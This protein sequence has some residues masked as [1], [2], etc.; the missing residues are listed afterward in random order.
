MKAVRFHSY[1][2]VDVL[3]YEDVPDPAAGAGEAVVR[4]RA[5]GVGRVDVALRSGQVRNRLPVELPHIPGLEFAGDVVELSEGVDGLSVGDRV[6]AVYQL[7]CWACEQCRAGRQEVCERA[8]IFGID[9][10]G[11]YAEYVV[12][13]T[14]ALVPLP[15]SLSY[16]E[17]AACQTTVGTAWHALLS[18]AR[19][20][21]G[22]TV[23]VSA[24]GSGVGSGG[25]VVGR[26]VGARVLASV[27]SEWKVE[28]ARAAG[29]DVVVDYSRED[30]TQRVLDETAG[31][32]VDVVLECVGGDV[33]R[34]SLAALARGGRIVVVGGHAGD[35]TEI[36]LA[37]LR[38]REGEVIGSTRA[39]QQEL[40]E[41]IG[42]AGSD[43]L[44]PPI[45][46]ALPLSEAG[47]AQELLESRE[48]YGK[49]VLN[50]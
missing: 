31:R 11:G 50:C 2:G 20:R 42:L 28:R 46:A 35:L 37:R 19:L 24:A 36:D 9:R 26:H 5:A 48:V 23:L 33:F 14:S 41:V 21:P 10:S 6:A 16:A 3:R 45:F 22:E 17:A 8:S 39:T 29:A 13:P 44:V 18:R 12:V 15:P 47:R 49:V 38:D 4:V 1:G 27:G 7:A 40:R 34:A 32:G 25:V 30:L 43:R